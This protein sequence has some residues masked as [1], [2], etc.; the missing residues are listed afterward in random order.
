MSDNNLQNEAQ[1]FSD[2]IKERVQAGHIPDLRRMTKND[3][4][5]QSYWR[6]P[7]FAGLFVGES[8]NI[9]LDLIRTHAP[10]ARTILDVGCGPGY[11]TLELARAGYH[12]VGIDIAESAIEIAKE[13]AA[14]NPFTEGFGSLEYHAIPFEQASG[15]YDVVLYSGSIHHFDDP[16]GVVKQGAALLN[17]GGLI[18]CHEPARDTWRMVDAAQAGLIRMLLMLTGV[19]YQQPEADDTHSDITKLQQYIQ[20]IFNEYVKEQE[21]GQDVQ[22]PQ[23]N[24]SGGQAILTALHRY[25]AEVAYR[26]GF[27]Y[28]YRM[29]GGLRGED[30]MIYRLADFL[31]TYEKLALREGYLLPSTYFWAGRVKEQ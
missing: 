21:K 12:V 26:P 7:Y 15:R 20:D 23:D 29:L 19:W 28:L 17:P 31:A 5:Y 13:T 10:Q 1:V 8:V 11:I 6:D 14:T 30:A 24:A 16:D 27:A 9:F 2:R 3:Y 22:S 4:F 25:A 18:V